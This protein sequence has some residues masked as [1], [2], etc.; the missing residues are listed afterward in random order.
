MGFYSNGY[1][2]PV[3]EVLTAHVAYHAVVL[4]RSLD[5]PRGE[6]CGVLPA[7]GERRPC[8]PYLC[9][10]GRMTTDPPM[11]MSSRAQSRR[12]SHVVGPTVRGRRDV[13]A[14]STFVISKPMYVEFIRGENI[15]LREGHLRCLNTKIEVERDFSS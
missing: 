15:K 4:R 7:T 2:A 8:P 9:Q 1:R 12:V 14:R 11:L 5:G 10:V 6:V 3:P 13:A